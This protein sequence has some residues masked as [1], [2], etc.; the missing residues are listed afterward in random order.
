MFRWGQMGFEPDA[1]RSTAFVNGH[2]RMRF[3]RFARV[4]I[5]SRFRSFLAQC[6]YAAPTPADRPP[7]CERVHFVTQV[8]T[9]L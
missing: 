7:H 9:P 4:D 5:E 1:L 3:G 2:F 8:L 6:V